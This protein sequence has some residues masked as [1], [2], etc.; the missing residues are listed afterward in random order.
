VTALPAGCPPLYAVLDVDLSARHGRDAVSVAAAFLAA[1]VSLLQIRGKSLGAA[2]LLRLTREVMALGPDARVIVN[3]R[4]DVAR[5]AEAG[6][7]HVGQD[8]LSVA[9][10]RTIV[11]PEPWV[12]LST[13]TTEQVRTALDQPVNYIA[14]GPVFDTGTKDTGYA[15]VGLDLVRQ[16][17]ALA[18]PRA[19]PVVAIG[20]ITLDQAPGV[21]AAG[22]SA[23]CV[24]SDLLRGDPEARARAFL[25]VLDPNVRGS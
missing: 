5:L 12:G 4:P 9:D 6:G 11:G 2:E 3:D 24:I 10:A 20:G 14:V 21:L 13:H 19:I 22:A 25:T 18:T 1:G 7:V 15:A 17:V 8:D 23:V 16:A